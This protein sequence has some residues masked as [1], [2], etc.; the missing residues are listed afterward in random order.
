[1]AY[2]QS[3]LLIMFK[4]MYIEIYKGEKNMFNSV[5]EKDIVRSKVIK[6]LAELDCEYPNKGKD[7]D[8]ERT[9]RIL[10]EDYLL[11]AYTGGALAKGGMFEKS[12]VD[13]QM[14]GENN[15]DLWSLDTLQKM[16]TYSLITE[17][18]N[19]RFESEKYNE[20]EVLINKLIES[21]HSKCFP[22]WSGG[23]I[24][25][26]SLEFEDIIGD[27]AHIFGLS[28]D[29]MENVLSKVIAWTKDKWTRIYVNN[30]S[31]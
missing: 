23:R 18:R 1:M 10:L 6:I 31:C 9:R 3:T 7:R 25:A 20:K 17:L 29:E 5:P 19:I 14:K 8:K 16:V 4:Y 22:I 27:W 21:Q 28:I 26:E 30:Q 13:I 11:A 15:F 24:R 12:K 2:A